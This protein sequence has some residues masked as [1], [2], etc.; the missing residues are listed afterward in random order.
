[1]TPVLTTAVMGRAMH[2][3]GSGGGLNST[4]AASVTTIGSNSPSVCPI[5]RLVRS[6][7]L[8]ERDGVLAAYVTD[9][10]IESWTPEQFAGRLRRGI[11]R[12]LRVLSAETI[13]T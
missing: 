3:M 4:T 8:L 6:G 5:Q 9:R 11:E 7:S 2:V 13:Y 1:M 12:G 10:L